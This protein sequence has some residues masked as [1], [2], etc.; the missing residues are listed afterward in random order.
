MVLPR[1]PQPRLVHELGWL[2]GLP[3]R[4]MDHSGGRKAPEF[5]TDQRQEFVGALDVGRR[6]ERL[7]RELNLPAVG[8]KSNI[9]NEHY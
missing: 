1:D 2:Q 5:R 9:N 6:A 3:G 4:F 8:A 7:H